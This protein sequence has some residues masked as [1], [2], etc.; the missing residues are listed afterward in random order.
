VVIRSVLD[1]ARNW[2][3]W[4]AHYR[5]SRVPVA[6]IQRVSEPF[7]LE[8]AVLRLALPLFDDFKDD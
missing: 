5:F 8:Q 3:F 1:T 6:P 2:L 7:R 4:G